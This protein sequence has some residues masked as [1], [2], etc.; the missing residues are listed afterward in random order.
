MS[1]FCSYGNGMG[2][3]IFGLLQN[4]LLLPHCISKLEAETHSTAL[5][6]LL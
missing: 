6:L 5:K 2:I 4:E 3:L 1:I